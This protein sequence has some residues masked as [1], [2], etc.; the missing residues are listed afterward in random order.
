VHKKSYINIYNKK[1]S[2]GV[3]F[4]KSSDCKYIVW[5]QATLYP[6]TTFTQAGNVCIYHTL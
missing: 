1:S 6:E 3:N 4:Q 2:Q 5:C